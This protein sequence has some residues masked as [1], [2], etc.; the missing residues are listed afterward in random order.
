MTQE[1]ILEMTFFVAGILSVVKAIVAFWFGFVPAITAD[2]QALIDD[3]EPEHIKKE[4]QQPLLDAPVSNDWRLGDE[5]KTEFF[6][7]Q[8]F[9]RMGLAVIALEFLSI[10]VLV[11]ALMVA[12]EDEHALKFDEGSIWLFY[13][14][15]LTNVI[16]SGAQYLDKSFRRLDGLIGVV[17]V[18]PTLILLHMAVK[19]RAITVAGRQ[20]VEPDWMLNA[21]HAA[22]INIFV[23]FVLVA[24][25]PGVHPAVKDV[26]SARGAE[27]G[28]AAASTGPRR[29]HIEQTQ[30]QSEEGWSRSIRMGYIFVRT[31]LR[32][33]LNLIIGGIIFGLFWMTREQCST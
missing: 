3:Q 16:W 19:H 1:T 21:I 26:M 6:M 20:A 2:K 7:T 18:C 11:G 31:V 17:S 15:W 4:G 8:M 32:I 33:V 5:K 25:T 13:L 23:E 24:V 27:S 9:R 22:A 29:R 30:I 10:A 12:L 14:F 28:A